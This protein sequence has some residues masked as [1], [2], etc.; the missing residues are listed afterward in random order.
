MPLQGRRSLE[1]RRLDKTV[2]MPIRH[3]VK[4]YLCVHQFSVL[5]FQNNEAPSSTNSNTFSLSLRLALMHKAPPF[6]ICVG[7][8]IKCGKRQ[9]TRLGIVLFKMDYNGRCVVTNLTGSNLTI[10][11]SVGWEY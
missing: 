9:T 8:C 3:G 10:K 7:A 5:A 4:Q 2:K 11:H 6:D 1:V